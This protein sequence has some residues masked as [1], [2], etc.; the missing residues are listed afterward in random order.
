MAIRTGTQLKTDM[1]AA[2]TALDNVI[3]PPALSIR[4]DNVATFIAALA[5]VESNGKDSRTV[6]RAQGLAKQPEAGYGNEVAAL[7]RAARK[8]AQ[9][10]IAK[11]LVP[12]WGIPAGQGV[13]I[14][15]EVGPVNVRP[16]QRLKRNITGDGTSLWPSVSRM[17][18][19]T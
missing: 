17:T 6:T 4:A 18:T 9:S 5:T 7:A 16:W 14:E 13:P 19:T 12:G 2:L 10:I 15:S 11:G 3:T 1:A 8:E